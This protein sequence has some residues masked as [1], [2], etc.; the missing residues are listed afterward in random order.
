MSDSTIT[1]CVVVPLF[2]IAMWMILSNIFLLLRGERTTGIV[3]DY[4]ARRGS[5]GG[6]T[7]AEVVEFKTADGKTIRFAERASRTRFVF[8]TGHS[9]NVIYD[10][11]KPHKARINSFFALYI[12]PIILLFVGSCLF[13]SNLSAFSDTGAELLTML[14]NLLNQIPFF[15]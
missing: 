15:K 13:V 14:Q 8:R 3:V 9:V 5:K 2:I 6:T 10:P 4:E 11:D 1:V 12:S 7:H